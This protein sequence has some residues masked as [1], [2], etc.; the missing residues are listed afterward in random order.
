MLCQ[1]EINNQLDYI[2]VA[3]IREVV[4]Q[5]HHHETHHRLQYGHIGTIV[6]VLT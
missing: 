6:Y 5:F 2:I 1:D 3:L 4:L